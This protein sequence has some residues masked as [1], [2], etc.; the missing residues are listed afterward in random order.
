MKLYFCSYWWT[1]LIKKFFVPMFLAEMLYKLRRW[2]ARSTHD[3]M[4]C[5]GSRLE[6]WPWEIDVWDIIWPGRFWSKLEEVSLT[7]QMLWTLY[8]QLSLLWP[9]LTVLICTF[10][11]IKRKEKSRLYFHTSALLSCSAIQEESNWNRLWRKMSWN[12]QPL[13]RSKYFCS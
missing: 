3:H 10:W 11:V 1:L 12:F 13:Q 4:H 7:I 5:I 6:V 2:H 9:F 8:M